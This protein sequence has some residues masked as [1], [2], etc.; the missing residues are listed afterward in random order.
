M[1]TLYPLDRETVINSVKKTGR[2]VVVQE[3]PRTCGYGAELIASI[4]EKALTSLQAPVQRV[5]GYDIPVPLPKLENYYI[6]DVTRIN[7]AIESVMSF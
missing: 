1:L 5:C 7:K 2:A 6:P 4:N 3:A